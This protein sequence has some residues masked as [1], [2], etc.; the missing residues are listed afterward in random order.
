[1]Q[2]RLS[3]L[4]CYR[5][6][7]FTVVVIDDV[8]KQ[9]KQMEWHYKRWLDRYAIPVEVKGGQMVINPELVIITSQYTPAQIWD[10]DS[11]TLSA[12]QRRVVPVSLVLPDGVV[13]SLD[14][15]TTVDAFPQ[16]IITYVHTWGRQY[17]GTRQ[18]CH[19]C[20]DFRSTVDPCVTIY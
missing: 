15:N 16:G 2:A 4:E 8:D 14:K 10:D 3:E 18:Y 1:M 19:T 5:L 12:I 17:L 11:E 9:V 7:I 13:G 20:K 6:F